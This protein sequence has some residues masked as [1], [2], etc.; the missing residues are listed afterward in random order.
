MDLRDEA[1]RQRD[2]DELRQDFAENANSFHVW[3]TETRAVMVDSQGDLEDQLKV[4]QEKSKEIQE[5]KEALSIVEDLGAQ[6][7]EAL[8][9]DNKYTEHSTVGLAQQW[10]Q[11]DQLAMRMR[12]NLEQQIQA[13]KMTGVPEETLKEFAANFR[14]FDK[15][16]SQFLDHQEFKSCLRSLG[17]DLP[18]I[19]EGLPEPEFEAILKTVDPNGDGVVSLSEYM[20]FM[21]SRET[22]NVHSSKDVEDAFKALTEGADKDFVTEQELYQSLSRPQAEYCIQHMKPYVDSRGREVPNAYDY[23]TFCSDLFAN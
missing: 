18:L 9:L 2:N 1:K 10:D 22:E 19:E 14:H 4:I 13:R 12:H 17:Y 16:K 21:I 7:E 23:K 20:A 8:I 3:L 11:L 5:R 15:N 6:M